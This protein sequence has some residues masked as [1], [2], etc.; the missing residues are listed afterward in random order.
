MSATRAAKHGALLVMVALLLFSFA[1]TPNNTGF[2][3]VNSYDD[4]KRAFQG[5]D[6]F[7]FPDISVFDYEDSGVSYE[8]VRKDPLDNDS[9]FIEYSVYGDSLLNE[10][11]IQFSVV[12]YEGQLD[13]LRTDVESVTYNGV[14]ISRLRMDKRNTNALYGDGFVAYIDGCEYTVRGTCFNTPS[15]ESQFKEISDA[16]TDI[17]YSVICSIIDEAQNN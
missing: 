15:D 5:K 3:R 4:V 6:H 17:T 8:I 11:K 10:I 2:I 9:P 13:S 1:C 14:N 7:I 12:G 16:I